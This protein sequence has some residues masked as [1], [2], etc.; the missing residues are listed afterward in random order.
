MSDNIFLI[1]Y[2]QSKWSTSLF[3]LLLIEWLSGQTVPGPKSAASF[4][5]SG[6]F[7]TDFRD[8]A[9]R[10]VLH[11]FAKVE[12]GK[13]TAWPT[14]CGPED[15][16]EG[17]LSGVESQYMSAP[18]TVW[19]Y[20]QGK[21]VGEAKI[22]SMMHG[23]FAI[24][25]SDGS[26]LVKPTLVDLASNLQFKSES[27]LMKSSVSARD[28]RAMS[29]LVERFP[30]T[31]FDHMPKGSITRLLELRAIRVS[32]NARKTFVGTA[33]VEYP[34]SQIRPEKLLFVAEY[35]N[36]RHSYEP[37]FADLEMPPVYSVIPIDIDGDGTDEL[38]VGPYILKKTELGEWKSATGSTVKSCS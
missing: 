30:P 28:R 29:R 13:I 23:S 5:Q 3:V 2:R 1:A 36:S 16:D 37:A 25:E 12:S 7:R 14:S 8:G 17:Y 15:A 34:G 38:V 18:S 19:L 4:R 35:N 6:I 10:G 31:W 27:E 33:S 22:T 32:A 20:S 24:V 21:V 11:P 26:L 9:R